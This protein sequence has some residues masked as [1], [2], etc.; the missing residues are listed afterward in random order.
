MAKVE[1]SNKEAKEFL[2]KMNQQNIVQ[3]KVEQ[4]ESKMKNKLSDLNNHLFEALERLNDEDL[5]EEE[6][7]KEIERSK[8]IT[9]VAHAIID[10]AQTVLKATEMLDERG[11]LANAQP[12]MNFLG[13]NTD[14]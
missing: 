6:M 3:C 13:L 12:T 7:T 10:N 8:A 1:L 11:Y 5:S 2:R 4:K 9:N 14:A